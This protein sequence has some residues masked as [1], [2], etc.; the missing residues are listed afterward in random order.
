MCEEGA[1]RAWRKAGAS[2]GKENILR[3]LLSARYRQ[4]EANLTLSLRPQIIKALTQMPTNHQPVGTDDFR[5]ATVTQILMDCCLSQLTQKVHHLQSSVSLS[6]QACLCV[7][8]D[9]LNVFTNKCN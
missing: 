9:I 4:L 6:T 5:K 3:T 2:K 1:C 7:L 8:G